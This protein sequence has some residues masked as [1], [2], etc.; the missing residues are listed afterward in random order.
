MPRFALLNTRPAHQARALKDLVQQAGGQS[1]AC[2]TLKIEPIEYAEPA[3]S[4][5]QTALTEASLWA[6]TSANAVA[7]LQRLLTQC[8]IEKGAVLAIGEATY[9][10][11]QN[12]LAEFWQRPGAQLLPPLH[13]Q[14]G[15]KRADSEALLTHPVLQKLTPGQSV[16]LIKGE[17]GRDH[18]Q[19]ALEQKGVNVIELPLYRRVA[20]PFC[21]DQ[22]Q[23]F[24]RAQAPKIILA[25]S[26]ESLKALWQGWENWQI[27]QKSTHLLPNLPLLVFSERIADLA[28]QA[29]WQGPIVVA[30]E[31][32]NSG[33]LQG[34]ETLI[35]VTYE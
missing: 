22:W 24:I 33:I 10:A 1:F 16:V 11:L 34:I 26:F 31:T 6:V 30:P 21:P 12:Q 15:Q 32:S 18:M 28:Q 19:R 23:A 4:A 25:T 2:P 3:V 17:G 7:P 29:G 20:A 14:G 5:W 13:L 35:G 27:S 8:A 9:Q